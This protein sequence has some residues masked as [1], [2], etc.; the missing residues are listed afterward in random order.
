MDGLSPHRRRKAAR[1]SNFVDERRYAW[2]MMRAVRQAQADGMGVDGAMKWRDEIIRLLDQALDAGLDRAEL[3]V[4]LA[5][6]G[7]RLCALCDIDSREATHVVVEDAEI[8]L[9]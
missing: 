9:N 3:I 7:A 2:R 1:M 6:I 5:N 4:E 8:C